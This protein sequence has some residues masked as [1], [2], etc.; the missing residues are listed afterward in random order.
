MNEFEQLDAGKLAA[1]LEQMPFLYRTVIV[2][3]S[4][5][6]CRISEPL[7]VKIHGDLNLDA[8]PAEIRLRSSYKKTMKHERFSYRLRP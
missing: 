4:A 6:V 8:Q 5:S 1:I 3:C 7:K 2:T